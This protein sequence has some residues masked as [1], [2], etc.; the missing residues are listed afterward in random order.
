M[1]RYS[2]LHS[3][4]TNNAHGDTPNQNGTP[5]QGESHQSELLV[6]T[7]RNESREVRA[8]LALTVFV[9]SQWVLPQALLLQSLKPASAATTSKSTQADSTQA[10]TKGN[11][12]S[13]TTSSKS[14]A[15]PTWYK[16]ARQKELQR[17]SQTKTGVK[18]LLAQ[19]TDR[20]QPGIT[21][22]PL[23]SDRAV[24][25]SG[26][27]LIRNTF[28]G[29]VKASKPLSKMP[30]MS[31]IPLR[32]AKDGVPTQA[33]IVAEGGL[34]G[35][36]SPVANAEVR[37]L[38]S[39]LDS[40]LKAEGFA[41]GTAT[42]FVTTAEAEAIGTPSLVQA[43]RRING[44]KERVKKAK[45]QNR[46]F[47]Q[48]IKQWND[49]KFQQANQSMD[50]FIKKYPKSPWTPEAYIHMGNYA[51]YNGRP[52]DS[53][54]A[55]RHVMDVT[56]ADPKEM[57]YNAH[58]KAFGRLTDL[59][60]IEQRFSEAR[61]MLEDFLYN[62]TNWRRR[63][64]ALY[65]LTQLN[66]REGNPRQ[67]L[68]DL[69]CGT[70][71]LAAL[72][73][74]RN[75]PLKA[76]NVLALK[77][78]SEKGFSFAELR[79]IAAKEGVQLAGFSGNVQQLSKLPMPVLLQYSA[80]RKG[81]SKVTD[82]YAHIVM[83][84]SY[85]AKR[86]LWQV[87]DPQDGSSSVL[88]SDELARQWSGKGLMLASATTNALKPEVRQASLTTQASLATPVATVAPKS[89]VLLSMAEM[90]STYGTGYG[91]RGQARLGRRTGRRGV[92]KS[93]A[94][95]EPD[96]S[97][98]YTS[99]NIYIADV[100][101]WY[102][103]SIGPKVE[104]SLSYNSLDA[105]NYHNFMGNKWTLNYGSYIVQMPSGSGTTSRVVLF[106]GDGAQETYY[107]LNTIAGT[108]N[109]MSPR[110]NYSKLTK[111]G[112]MFTLTNQ[113]G[114][115]AIYTIPTLPGGATTTLPYLTRLVDRWGKTLQ[116]NHGVVHDQIVPFTVQ[117]ADL[118]YTRFQYDAEGR[119][120]YVQT[121]DQ[122]QA[123][124]TYD[125]YGNLIQC[126]DCAGQ[127]FQY[128]Y[129]EMATI[130]QLNTPQ[131]P[132]TFRVDFTA[133]AGGGFN[134]YKTSI[135]DPSQSRP[136][137]MVFETEASGPYHNPGHYYYVDR[138]GNS[139]DF[140]VGVLD[141]PT[142]PGDSS[143]VSS[144]P[145]ITKLAPPVGQS[146]SYT[147]EVSTA[148]NLVVPTGMTSG[149][150]TATF[151]YNPQGQ[152]TQS[153]SSISGASKTN[154]FVYDGNGLDLK[155]ATVSGIASGTPSLTQTLLQN[156][157]YDAYHQ[158]TQITDG[159]GNVTN[160]VYTGWGAVDSSTTSLGSTDYIYGTAGTSLNRLTS[161]VQ[162]TATIESY[163]YDASGRTN[164]VT[165]AAG[166]VTKYRYNDLDA[167]TSFMYADGTTVL[168][169][170]TCCGL[171]GMVTDR[172]GRRV[173]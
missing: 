141:G 78:R 51:K 71:A 112:S 17:V 99:Q 108:T 98:D 55:Y 136:E 114:D 4:S 1:S 32:L 165:D 129:D 56:S 157:N 83:L 65:W 9:L 170:Y 145:I 70:Q 15:M 160:Y 13:L 144:Y 142:P 84:R 52:N 152:M 168:I 80:A 76:R 33:Q 149:A 64:W 88:K 126:I 28:P 161:V 57:S 123:R 36:L 118:K 154:T 166:S 162:G 101:L 163:T 106:S 49:N 151:T 134:N 43:A 62:D 96:V 46:E 35:P 120:V 172:S 11:L 39:E 117:D 135:Y 110:G 25:A 159:A 61:P 148:S 103:P 63:T 139:T 156:A 22:V 53:E 60:L 74:E 67:L 16:A 72:L 105:T 107:E 54:K 82:P 147:Y 93:C 92:K 45:D 119:L 29:D 69:D 75:L 6:V 138:R 122:K 79:Q 40:Q 169:D 171:P 27:P 37:E 132:W 102:E 21:V 8:T 95:G 167:P 131:G 164:G 121:P 87:R 58:R 133:I 115:R 137:A 100:P 109:Y 140:E 3:R 50:N 68:A 10:G 48:A 153:V 42:P 23:Q 77:P 26:A 30:H 146:S 73:H 89:P 14:T 66:A 173:Y 85:D 19:N 20:R 47:L 155:S 124:F 128:A 91:V 158:P 34:A 125:T 38:V 5:N 150:K 104:I 44:A 31:S 143:P 86:R 113:G 130:T 2:S 90:R 41:G 94:K 18:M 12:S 24:A 116:I 81:A 127:A 59:Y 97:V 7:R 111:A